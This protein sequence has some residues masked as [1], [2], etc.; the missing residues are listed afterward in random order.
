K[1]TILQI[2][3]DRIRDP[4]K[5]RNVHAELLSLQ[6]I[7]R[8]ENLETDALHTLV[9]VLKG[10]NESL[11]DIEDGVRAHEARGDFGGAFVALARGVYQI[12]D[13]RARIKKEINVLTGSVFVEEKSY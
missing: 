13:E 9:S 1:L 6:K 12:N 10:I 5:L 11:W 3:A 8:A 7:W 4:E 2:K